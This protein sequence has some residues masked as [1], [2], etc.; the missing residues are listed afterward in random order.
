MDGLQLNILL[1]LIFLAGMAIGAVAM[2]AWMGRKLEAAKDAHGEASDKL[3]GLM[4][5]SSND[6]FH[7]QRKVEEVCAYLR[8]LK[9]GTAKKA[10]R[11][12]GLVLMD[13]YR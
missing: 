6:L 2:R 10:S 3:L 13:S 4:E 9:V 7:L 12:L 5:S 1:T 11:L 8:P